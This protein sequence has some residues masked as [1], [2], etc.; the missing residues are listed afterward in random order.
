MSKQHVISL[1]HTELSLVYTKLNTTST[2][3]SQFSSDTRVGNS[4]GISS[5]H[6]REA[7]VLK[8]ALLTT[9]VHSLINNNAFAS[10]LRSCR[11]LLPYQIFYCRRFVTI[12]RPVGPMASLS[13]HDKDSTGSGLDH[14]LAQD[15]SS[16]AY[17]PMNLMGEQI[18]L[19]K[20]A[21]TL[22]DFEDVYCDITLFDIE[23]APPYVALSY[24]WGPSTPT[25]NV[26]VG[27]KE[28]SVRKNLYQFLQE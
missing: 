9:T 25:Y 6:E 21:R 14:C 23:D 18:R 20:L 27:G 2:T 26:I 17:Q 19:I 8:C 22:I 16:Y 12:E 5:E 7:K 24:T 28:V 10:P 13:R 1:S 4:C 3:S 11:D 15:E